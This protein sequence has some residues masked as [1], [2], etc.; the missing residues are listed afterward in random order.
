[1]WNHTTH[2]YISLV[3]KMNE[4]D[5]KRKKLQCH[6]EKCH[7]I[8]THASISRTQNSFFLFS[9]QMHKNMK[10]SYSVVALPVL[11][12]SPERFFVVVSFVCLYSWCVA[13]W[14]TWWMLR[15]TW[16][17]HPRFHFHLIFRCSLF[18]TSFCFVARSLI[19]C[20]N[21]YS[22]GY[23]A[24][25]MC[26]FFHSFPPFKRIWKEIGENEIKEGEKKMWNE[27]RLEPNYGLIALRN[28]GAETNLQHDWTQTSDAE[29][30]K[31]HE[32]LQRTMDR[33]TGICERH[34]GLRHTFRL[35]GWSIL[36]RIWTPQIRQPM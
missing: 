7:R 13:V 16:H 5:E 22:S 36:T 12:F 14:T 28:T 2:T 17:F 18:C 27:K 3:N 9:I 10:M 26:L 19:V 25:G 20:L 1:M 31:E 8:P 15:N 33:M 11:Y 6:P 35:T 4:R 34:R 29:R 30:R 32:L 24:S 23:V 21:V